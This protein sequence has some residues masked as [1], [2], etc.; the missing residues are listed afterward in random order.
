MTNQNLVPNKNKRNFN[1]TMN[2]Y[3]F[4]NERIAW[5]ETDQRSM[6]DAQIRVNA[7]ILSKSLD[8]EGIA[9]MQVLLKNLQA[10]LL[11]Y[12]T[13]TCSVCGDKQSTVIYMNI[14]HVKMEMSWGYESDFDCENHSLVLCCKCCK[15]YTENIM[16][17]PLG[18]F[19]KI[20]RYH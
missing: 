12:Q 5:N 18:K 2:I 20:Q 9:T 4:G 16:N 8:K 14:E 11:N 19:V 10:D 17:G 1:R 6:M 13:S 15:C 3:A 7:L